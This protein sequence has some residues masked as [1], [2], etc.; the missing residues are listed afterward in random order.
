MALMQR[1]QHHRHQALARALDLDDAQ[2]QQFGAGF[3]THRPSLRAAQREVMAQRFAYGDALA[4]GDEA[5]ARA[6]Q[7]TLSSAQARLDSL[8]ADMMMQEASVL[9]PEQRVRYIQWMFRPG[10]GPLEAFGPGGGR[11]P[12]GGRGPGAPPPAPGP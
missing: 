9:R 5:A 8:C 11:G 4:R 6:A 7:R 1:W 3:E 12:H 2:R 10:A